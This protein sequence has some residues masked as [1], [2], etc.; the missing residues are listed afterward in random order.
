MFEKGRGPTK[1]Y[2][3]VQTLRT[4]LK[5]I[6]WFFFFLLFWF[7][8]SKVRVCQ[9]WE[10]RLDPPMAHKLFTGIQVCNFKQHNKCHNDQASFSL[11]IGTV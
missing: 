7:F 8:F 9:T 2:K 5:D 3:E 4:F 11:F 10:F 1:S 6:C